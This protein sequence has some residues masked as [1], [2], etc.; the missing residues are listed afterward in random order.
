[1][2]PASI[3]SCVGYAFWNKKVFIDFGQWTLQ[4]IKK[5]PE[6][7]IN[8]EFQKEKRLELVTL[9][10]NQRFVGADSCY[11]PRR[12]KALCL[13]QETLTFYCFQG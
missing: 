10:T 1:M 8:R 3:L 5:P 7:L 13:Y 6:K 9:T 12:K 4:S 11:S 2:G